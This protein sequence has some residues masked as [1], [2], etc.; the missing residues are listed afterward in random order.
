MTMTKRVLVVAAHPDDEILGS[1]GTLIRHAQEG[2]EVYCF[3]LGEGIMSRDA[4]TAHER[5][6]LR[7][8][9]LKAGKMIGFK[10]MNFAN[11]PDNAFDTVGL[12]GIVKEVEQKLAEIKPERIYTHHEYDLN[13]DH[14]RTFQAVLTAC[15]P[16]NADAPVEIL[17]FETLSSTEWQHRDAKTFQPNVYINIA[18]TLEKKIEAMK[19]YS[20]EVRSF[21]HPRSPEGIRILAQYRGMESGLQYAEAFCLI[22]KVQK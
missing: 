12:L 4:A 18:D 5:D 1:G 21:P 20:T 17:T 16:C 10:K 15:R 14:Q 19:K 11:F 6:R 7:Q 8:D 3:I 13:I 9:T 2:D 22:R